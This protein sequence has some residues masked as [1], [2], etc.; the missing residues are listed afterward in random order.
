MIRRLALA[1]LF[2]LPLAACD[3]GGPSGSVTVMSQN[4]YLGADI[5]QLVLEPNPQMVPVRVA[6]ASA[7][8]STQPASDESRQLRSGARTASRGSSST[9]AL[10]R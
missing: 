4:L 1:L 10:R 3:S 9:P 2:A 6:E 7:G 5:F 8:A